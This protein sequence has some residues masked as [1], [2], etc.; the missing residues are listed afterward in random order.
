MG[1]T[2]VFDTIIIY[3][4]YLGGAGACVGLNNMVKIIVKTAIKT[5]L[6]LA[7]IMVVVGLRVPKSYLFDYCFLNFSIFCVKEK[8]NFVLRSVDQISKASV[9]GAFIGFL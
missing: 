7:A 6:S 8:L 5:K 1:G 4:S 3:A 2:F 9:G